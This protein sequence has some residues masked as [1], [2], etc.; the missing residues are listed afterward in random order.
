MLRGRSMPRRLFLLFLILS[1]SATAAE[2]Q[3]VVRALTYATTKAL[4]AGRG[5][6][7]AAIAGAASMAA[8]G[9]VGGTAY[10]T[11]NNLTGNVLK[12]A[13]KP[14]APDQRPLPLPPS[15]PGAKP[16]PESSLPP[17]LPDAGRLTSA[18]P[19]VN[20]S[21]GCLLAGCKPIDLSNL[22]VFSPPA[23]TPLS[24][25]IGP[26]PMPICDGSSL[27]GL[28]ALRRGANLDSG[29][30]FAR[31]NAAAARTCYYVAAQ[32]N[33]PIAQFNLADMLLNGDVGVPRNED[34]GFE[35]MEAA[36]RNG[37]LPAQIRLGD[38]YDKG[39]GTPPNPSAAFDWFAA[40][41]NA[42]STYAQYQLSRFFYYGIAGR[43]DYVG[44]FVWL[45]AALIGGYQPAFA[46]MQELLD[47]VYADAR[48]GIAGAQF[49]AGAASEFGVPGLIKPD[50]RLAFLAYRDAQRGNWSAAP[51]AVQR[52]CF[53]FPA[54][55]F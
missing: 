52:V 34:R 43:K 16:Q 41:A 49:I 18:F 55:C 20:P 21:S 24:P 48:T 50:P 19:D 26:P 9:V 42:G 54:A 6:A 44:A 39:E 14:Q 32:Q 37:F 30:G 40:A 2:A 23:P 4:P 35:Y 25:T 13:F 12:N 36:A 47:I 15:P 7:I 1:L 10:D 22:P 31:R 33:I 45:N 17:S 29:S 5:Y 11:L 51:S 28:E 8:G 27:D 53:N 38:A 3:A 46:T